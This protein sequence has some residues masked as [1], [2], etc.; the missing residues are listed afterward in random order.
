MPLLKALNGSSQFSMK[1]YK[2]LASF[3]FA[4][5]LIFFSAGGVA[6]GTFLESK[7]DSHRLA[8][9]WIYHHPVFQILLAGYFLNILLSALSRYPFKKSHIPFLIT[10][11]G[12]LM[13]ISGVFIKSQYGLQGHIQLIEG[14]ATNT[15][16]DPKIPAV[17]IEKRFP[18]GFKSIPLH[19]L[20]PLEYYP[21]AEEKFVSWIFDDQIHILG[22][23][24]ISHSPFSL[25][26][27]FGT[28]PIHIEN[29]N[30]STR[31]QTETTEIAYDPYKLEEWIAYDK[32]FKGYTLQAKIPAPLDILKNPLIDVEKS[33]ETYFKAWEQKGTWLNDSPFAG[34][35]NWKEAPES[36][37]K[38]LYW[39]ANLFEEE[40]FLDQL[41][42]KGWPL[43]EQLEAISG[44]EE[45][46]FA[47]MNQIFAVKDQLP[48]PETLS[49]TTS[50]RML[51]AY[52]RLAK[53]ITLE[54]PLKHIIEQ[55]TPPLKIEEATPGIVI[56]FGNEK[57][58]LIYDPHNTRL[59]WPSSDGNHLLKF[60]PHRI[61]LPF[62]IRLHQARDIKYPGS[63]QTASYECS[64]SVNST[65]CTLRMNQVHET[66]EGYR[67]YL[68]GMGKIDPYGV[69]SVQLVVNH[70][71]AKMLLTYP[72][73]IL[74]A[75]GIILLFFKKPYT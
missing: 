44:K 25:E 46:Y 29:T 31:I 11:L 22:L 39:I 27:T 4:L 21:H 19:K 2:F 10:H 28:I 1:I 47:W 23:P 59:K 71:P 43:V 8:E 32:G 3:R 16:T 65:P 58:P 64:I 34:P 15:F 53:E 55:K 38:A 33:L 20:S 66:P 18:A 73:G 56:S 9:E 68:A 54:S 17:F 45:Q 49:P 62:S 12:L 72:G 7:A 24:P 41:K 6:L 67:L 75:L 42:T 48:S 35:I 74:V 63:N 70:D 51:S 57:I 36:T 40:H 60:Q 69:H 52:L 50:A 61:K 14:T 13:L 26:T 5:L 37:Y 30:G